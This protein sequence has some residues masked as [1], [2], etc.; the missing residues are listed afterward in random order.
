MFE[1]MTWTDLMPIDLYVDPNDD[2]I[3]RWKFSGTWTLEKYFPLN[4]QAN[5]MVIERAPTPV[6]VI[7]DLI[8]SAPPP[9]RFFEGLSQTNERGPDNWAVTFMVAENQMY[10]RLMELAYRL[11][12]NLQ[13]RY[14]VVGSMEEARAAVA[15]M[16]RGNED[17][18]TTS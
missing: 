15:A 5:Q 6:Y 10:A 13:Q 12:R 8:E 7:V 18:E 11:D 2:N 9:P 3:L 4:E 14:Y 17:A 1:E 16:R